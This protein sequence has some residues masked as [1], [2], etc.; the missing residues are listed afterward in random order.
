MMPRPYS[1]ATLLLLS[2]LLAGC[3]T[4]ADE[5][6]LYPLR[7]EYEWSEGD[8]RGAIVWE[9]GP[10]IVALASDGQEVGGRMAIATVTPGE[11]R[12]LAV[13]VDVEGGFEF[14]SFSRC[15]P[16]RGDL[17]CGEGFRVVE[18]F[19]PSTAAFAGS[20]F[21]RTI[22]LAGGRVTAGP[23]G[24]TR[25]F[26]V[27]ISDATFTLQ[28][29]GA[30]TPRMA[31]C[32]AFE[33]RVKIDIKTRIV[34]EC[35][36]G[37]E[38]WTLRSNELGEMPTSG[39]SGS[40]RF[41]T[42]A[43]L[44]LSDALPPGADLQLDPARPSLREGFDY[45]MSAS[46]GL[47]DF[48]RV[49]PLAVLSMAS[50]DPVGL[51]EVAREVRE[52]RAECT[53]WFVGD[54]QQGYEVVVRNSTRS[55]RGVVFPPEWSIVSEDAKHPDGSAPPDGAIVRPQVGVSLHVL[56]TRTASILGEAPDNVVLSYDAS[57]VGPEGSSQLVRML[58]DCGS[59][60][61]Q[62]TVL[63]DGR[64]GD[65]VGARLDGRQLGR[66]LQIQ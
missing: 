5:P 34:Q 43:A 56:A 36:R 17:P 18:W 24:F 41:A 64:S 30:P 16:S 50:C 51:V 62:P 42:V 48:L 20:I 54:E 13:A 53:F 6:P 61:L 29:V 9:W 3:A 32:N 39:Q 65:L 59:G 45:A 23:E 4:T 55:V 25:E 22:P 66:L 2:P 35:I 7:L 19:D 38:R 14:V 33:D 60:C 27:A 21:A 52:A 26:E 63:F 28:P 8:E 57:L 15:K 58:L 37:A 40:Q 31:Y 46:Q 49:Y 10:P 44:P 12:T 1:A 47:S 11:D